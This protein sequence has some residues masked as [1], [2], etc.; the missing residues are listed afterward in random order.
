MDV[1]AYTEESE[2]NECAE[3]CNEDSVEN[4]LA[5]KSEQS[6]E[7]AN[8]QCVNCGD[9]EDCCRHLEGLQDPW[10][11]EECFSL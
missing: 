8:K 3:E 5:G 1:T 10:F 6:D 7:C 9:D 2:P 11:G 4:D